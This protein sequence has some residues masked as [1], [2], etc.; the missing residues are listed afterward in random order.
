M[1]RNYF[2]PSVV[3]LNDLR[4]VPLLAALKL[5]RNIDSSIFVAHESI[6]QNNEYA[7]SK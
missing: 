3:I 7:D 2:S 1:N 6:F 4:A 5:V